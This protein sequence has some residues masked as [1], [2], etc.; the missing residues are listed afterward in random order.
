[1]CKPMCEV[2]L[3]SYFLLRVRMR[4][5]QESPGGDDLGA[6]AAEVLPGVPGGEAGGPKRQAGGAPGQDEPAGADQAQPSGGAGDPAPRGRRDEAASGGAVT[7]LWSRSR[8]K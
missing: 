6:A 7:S 2:M 5:P 3:R 4:P 1:M 8:G